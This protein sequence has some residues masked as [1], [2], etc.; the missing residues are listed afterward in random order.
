MP[1]QGHAS[2]N[3]SLSELAISSLRHDESDSNAAFVD[4]GTPASHRPEASQWRICKNASWGSRG[5]SKSNW[6]LPTPLSLHNVTPDSGR[7]HAARLEFPVNHPQNVTSGST[8]PCIWRRTRWVSRTISRARSPSRSC[9]MP[10]PGRRGCMVCVLNC[11]FPVA[12]L[13]PS[14]MS[15][16]PR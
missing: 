5:N 12:P 6:R 10:F 7:H 11:A 9:S 8:L 13:S 14:G 1:V 3:E 2:G 15:L 16:V 4:A